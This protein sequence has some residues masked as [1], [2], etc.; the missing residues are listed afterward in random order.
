M[1]RPYQYF[2]TNTLTLSIFHNKHTLSIYSINT[3]Y[4]HTLSIYTTNTHYQHFMSIQV[5][6]H[7]NAELKGEREN[8]TVLR[9]AAYCMDASQYVKLVM[10]GQQQQQQQQQQHDRHSQFSALATEIDRIQKLV[11]D[12]CPPGTDWCIVLVGREK[13]AQLTQL[14]SIFSVFATNTN[15]ASNTT[16][17]T[18]Q[19]LMQS[20]TNITASTPCRRT[21]KHTYSSL[22]YHVLVFVT[23]S[24]IK[25]HVFLFIFVF[26][27]FVVLTLFCLCL[28]IFHCETVLD[29]KNKETQ[30]LA[31]HLENNNLNSLI[32][33]V[34][35]RSISRLYVDDVALYPLTPDYLPTHSSDVSDLFRIIAHISS[36]THAP[37]SHTL[38][39]PSLLQTLVHN[40]YNT[41]LTLPLPPT[42][43]PPLIPPHPGGYFSH[44]G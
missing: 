33:Q 20:A 25:T 38:S 17:N 10:Q 37:F 40:L 12:V 7:A 35:L 29:L 26:M 11:N 43:P 1:K 13:G 4:Q 39:S 16:T 28:Y 8:K 42:P 6:D 3:L 27:F 21:Y 14:L 34:L 24:L 44:V 2:I 32:A 36:L 22:S 18:I 5:D 19:P 41:P 30:N 9:Y 15:T 31:P 23:Y